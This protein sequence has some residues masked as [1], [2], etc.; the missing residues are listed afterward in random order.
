MA[1][2]LGGFETLIEHP[3]TMTHCTLPEEERLKLGIT[4]TF[5]RM[6]VGLEAVQDIIQDM[7]QAMKSAFKRNVDN[8]DLL[9]RRTA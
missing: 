7:D 3:A 6:S 2:S 8:D 9:D 5:I 1:V 4:D